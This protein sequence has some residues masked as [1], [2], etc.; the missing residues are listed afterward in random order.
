MNLDALTKRLT[1]LLEGQSIEWVRQDSPEHVTIQ[2]K[3]GP[4]AYFGIPAGTNELVVSIVSSEDTSE[5]WISKVEG[6]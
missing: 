5:T 6:H 4:M 1:F 2:F 3:N